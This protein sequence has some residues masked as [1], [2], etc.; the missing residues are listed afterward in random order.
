MIDPYPVPRVDD[1]LD[2]L[3][4]AKFI[5]TLD[6]TRGYWQVP[7]SPDA[8]EKSAFLTRN[9]HYQFIVM[10]FGMVNSGATFQRLMDRVLARCEEFAQLYVDEVLAKSVSW[11]DHLRHLREMLTCLCSAGLTT[12]PRKCRV[13]TSKT[14][15]LGHVAG[16]GSL[17]PNQAKIEPVQEFSRLMT[18]QEVRRFLGLVGYYRRFIPNFARVSAPLVALTRK[19]A[20]SDVTWDD[21]CGEAFQSLKD[22]LMTGPVLRCPDYSRPFVLQTDASGQGLG[23]VLAQRDDD[24]EEHPVAYLSRRLQA[25]EQNYST[26][27]KECLAVVWEVG[28]CRSNLFGHPF[29][30]ESDHRPLEWLQKMKGANARLLRWSLSLQPY[31][32]TTVYRKG[33]QNV[34]ADALSRI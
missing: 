13:V 20:P 22:A 21:A 19:G 11:A 8:K 23:A 4:E 26:V 25:H 7:L 32:I 1:L 30:V 24:G 31:H 14:P 27:E 18:K 33:V 29:C 2:E 10:P 16:N 12:K 34:N 9:G 3:G 17:R 28:K 5:S 15:C 6:L